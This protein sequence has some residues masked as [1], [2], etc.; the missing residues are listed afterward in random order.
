[1][2]RM[3]ELEG[4]VLDLLI[5]LGNDQYV[6]EI[7]GHTITPENFLGI[8]INP[9]AAAIAQ[10]VLWIG[11]LQ[12]HFRVNG[13][14]RAPPEPILRDIKTIEN[15]D[16]LITYEKREIVN[17]EDGNPITRWDGET[18]KLSPVTGQ[19][20]PDESARV[21]VYRYIKPV[22]AKWPRA[23]FIVGNPPFIGKRQI[24]AQLGE[25]YVDALRSVHSSVPS[26]ADFVMYWWDIAAALATRN[27]VRRFGLVTTNSLTQTF[28]RRILAKHLEKRQPISLLYAV[29]DAPWVDEKDGAAVRVAM[30]VAA[31]GSHE[32]RL[33][34]VVKGSTPSQDSWTV[35]V[36]I[37]CIGPD[38][39]VGLSTAD[40]KPLKANENLCAVGFQLNG[41]GFAI[42]RKQAAEWV[43][44]NPANSKVIFPLRNGNDLNGQPRDLFC[45]DLHGC[46][47]LDVRDKYPDIFQW[48]HA[49]VKPERDQNNEESRRLNWWL[50]GRS[51][52][53]LRLAIRDIDKMVV[54]SVTSKHRFFSFSSVETRID[55][56]A[57]AIALD[58]AYYLGILSSNIYTTWV[59][60]AGGT[61]EDRPRFNKGTCF[62]PFPF[63]ADVSD[64]LKNLIRAEAEALDALREQVLADHEDLTLTKLYNVL[65]ALRAGKPLSDAERDIHNRGLV[66]VIKQ[67][68]DRI[69]EA[70]AEAYG[71]PADLSDEEIL[72]RLVDLNRARAAEEAKGLI[73]WLRPEFQAPGYEAPISQTLD[74]G[75][76]I[77]L[78]DNIVPWPGSLPEQVSAVQS[79]LTNSPTPLAPQDVARAF[80]GK[81]ASTVRPVLDALAG[82]GMARR[83]EDGRYAA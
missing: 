78:P 3:K 57:F 33:E 71:W 21:K 83:L 26:G 4:E 63:A 64:N 74:L 22:A 7:T 55:S 29:P 14:D 51:N 42:A 10:L 19:P 46:S 35:S 49:Y 81:R 8:E 44:H 43:D 68:H 75:E 2:A 39:K 66:T 25:D 53:A 9:R 80:K 20:V 31:A 41:K 12:W 60:A 48:V 16:A 70:V 23:D 65:E 40:A 27:Q 58:D 72:I 6:A 24:K 67:H 69:D 11:Y 82:I 38:L 18:I 36:Q 79:V 37:G 28:S 56:T 73:R 76:T 30:T 15:R 47:E 34:T 61:L 77:V 13:P 5:E 62:A 50:F 1:M 17:D 32:G 45:I 52:E 54:S 59:L